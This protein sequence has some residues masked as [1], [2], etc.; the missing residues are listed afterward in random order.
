MNCGE[1][2]MD[3]EEVRKLLETSLPDCDISVEG[4]GSHFQITVVG[5][6]F[7][8]L[9]PIKRQQLVY[10]VLDKH[11][12]GGDIHAVNMITLARSET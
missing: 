2:M 9:R 12:A 11:I 4:D 5:D 6:V 1:K 3:T 7:E 10:G 8:G